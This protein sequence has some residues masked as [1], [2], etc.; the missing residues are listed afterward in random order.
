L[1]QERDFCCPET[2]GMWKGTRPFQNTVNKTDN[3]E[4]NGHIRDEDGK[5]RIQTYSFYADHDKKDKEK[6]P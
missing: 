2:V 6:N 5:E 1:I 4:E 3:K